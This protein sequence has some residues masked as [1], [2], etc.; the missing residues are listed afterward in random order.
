MIRIK[1]GMFVNCLHRYFGASTNCYKLNLN[2]S[3]QVALF[4]LVMP[5][6]SITHNMKAVYERFTCA[7]VRLQYCLFLVPFHTLLPLLVLLLPDH[8]LTDKCLQ[9]TCLHLTDES[10][11]AVRNINVI[12]KN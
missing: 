12:L 2:I 5:Q 11:R 8:R 3:R 1:G 10:S 7:P 6:T 4:L 9:D